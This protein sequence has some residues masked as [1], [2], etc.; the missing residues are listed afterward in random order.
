MIGS[1][2]EAS[3]PLTYT[4][5]LLAFVAATA[6]CLGAAWRARSVP[7]P[8]T[9]Q[10]L[11]WFFSGSAVWAGA[12]VGFLLVG[13]ALEKHLFYQLSLIVGFGT[14]FAWLWF[15]SAYSGRGLHRN[16][17]VQQFAIAVYVIVTALKVTNPLHGLYYGLEPA[18][19]AFGLV[20]THETLYWVVMAVA[21]A[22]SAAGYLMLLE[23]FLKAGARTGP[24]AMLTG[25]TAL[26]AVFNVIGHVQ[27]ALLDITHE[28]LGVA[29][30][31]VGLML[32]YE[33]RFSV[34]QLTGSV[35]EPNL[36]IGSD[37]RIRG[38]GGGIKETVP[39]LSEEDLGRPLREALPGLAKTIEEG[40]AVWRAGF[41]G[42]KVEECQ[43]S[44]PASRPQ[45]ASG[46]QH[47]SSIKPKE[48]SKMVEGT[49]RAGGDTQPREDAQP[50]GH[51]NPEEVSSMEE[52]SGVEDASY[53]DTGAHP[54]EDCRYFQVV[55]VGAR[56]HGE[57][58]TVV[59]SDITERKRRTEQLKEAKKQAE[60]SKLEAEEASRM[61]SAM[62]A[63]MSHEIR[64]PLTGVIGFAEAIG[65][66]TGE[67]ETGGNETGEGDTGGEDAEGED[68][69]G[70][71]GK[72]ARFAGLI[73]DSGRRLL[74]T[75]DAVLN[76]SKLEAGKMS[77]QPEPVDLAGQARQ[78]AR[79]FE[80][81][82]WESGLTLEVQTEEAWARADE[83]GLK[84]VLQNLLS[85][86][87]KYTEE[88]GVTVRTYRE[89]EQ[90][91]EN[92]QVQENRQVQEDGQA[93][94]LEVEDSGI[95]MDPEVAE[96]LFEPFRQASEGMSRE[97]EGT[98]I[99]LAVTKRA[100]EE[101]GGSI[102]VDTQK[103]EGSRFTVR[104][105]A[106]RSAGSAE[107]PDDGGPDGADRHATGRSETD[108]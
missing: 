97:Y 76:L 104:F 60:L 64:T 50:V 61:K 20:V 108:R 80:E 106:A 22:L 78:V 40:G 51:L 15:C 38:L 17:R 37:G 90:S 34:V 11:T 58:R 84:I 23:V 29:V 83:G 21:Y 14:V 77:L 30:F 32:A 4:G 16:R 99:G 49:G 102:E 69:G 85:N 93:V 86:A 81:E 45:P 59:L 82:A 31:A 54:E 74:D 7:S 98:G 94:V 42:G 47:A 62:L 5:Y 96:R 2:I 3:T 6:A 24:L 55:E 8:E 52:V 35:G 95:G 53:L 68:T 10:A 48:G 12:Y 9:R 75:L 101:M 27:P 65:E 71:E 103:K 70:E 107:G 100:A 57:T 13:S 67:N 19:G 88:G 56:A 92:E 105:P 43:D 72:V 39:P 44:E 26:P 73:E 1:L 66:E 25:L 18:G 87:I 36:T 79:E 89:D 63:N 28:P 33:T 46:P 41:D 91:Q